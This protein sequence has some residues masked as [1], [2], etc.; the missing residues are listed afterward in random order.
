MPVT[1]ERTPDNIVITL[2]ATVDPI[3]VQ[4]LLSRF[5]FMDILSRSQATEDDV[6]ELADSVNRGMTKSILDKLRQLDE[7]KDLNP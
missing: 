1:I 4:R 3:D 7:F 6:K 5:Q 2:P